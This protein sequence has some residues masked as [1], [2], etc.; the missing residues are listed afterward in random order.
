MDKNRNMLITGAVA[1]TAGLLAVIAVAFF[2]LP[3]RGGPKLFLLAALVIMTPFPLA[4]LVMAFR[5]L[6]EHSEHAQRYA[7]RDPL[8]DLYNQNAF[9]DFLNYEIERSKRQKYRFSLMLIDID[10]FKA[11]NDKH[12]HA[13]G[14]LFLGR[15]SDVF[16][17]TI[18]KGDIPARY[19]GDNFAAILPVCDEAQA[20]I[21]AKRLV[22]ALRETTVDLPDGSQVVTTASV[23]ISVFPHHAGDAQDLFLLADSMLAQAKS[24]GKDRVSVPLDAVSIESLKS[25]G[26][27]SLLVMEAIRQRRIVPYF[28]PIISV[29]GSSVLAY[30][31]LT[32]IVTAE[33]VIPAAEFIDV[34]ESMGAMSRLT[35]MLMDQAFRLAN[36]KGYAG[37]LF[38][39]LS[40]KALVMGDFLPRIR[41]IMAEHGF[42]AERIVFEITERDTV[43]N[44][45]LIERVVKELRTE[46]FRF[47]IDDFG[48]GYSSFQYIRLF[49]V[50]YLKVDGEF[51]RNMVGEQGTEKAIVANIASL[52]DSLGIKTIA[53]YVESEAILDQVRSSGIQHAQGYHI[54][55]PSPHLSYPSATV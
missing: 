47:A 53:E 27:R 45:G 16:K 54:N 38:I 2:T 4:M 1:M 31:V 5:A 50:D 6:R 8:T 40:P 30:E 35:S 49:T 21:V 28:Q 13:A 33:R 23:G 32:R 7:T 22:D 36:E 43:K 29:N 42:L 17:A 41:S 20:H 24:A 3:G 51:I 44:T 46:G 34:A 19:A 15:F 55:R 11:I 37:T 14:D 9:W 25:A 10:N 26:E 48:S 12:G 18:R 39:N 52:A